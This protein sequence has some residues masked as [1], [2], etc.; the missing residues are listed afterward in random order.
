MLG[1]W[2]GYIGFSEHKYALVVAFILWRTHLSEFEDNPWIWVRTDMFWCPLHRWS[3]HKYVPLLWGYFPRGAEELD[4]MNIWAIQ[5]VMGRAGA[6]HRT[7]ACVVLLW[8]HLFFCRHFVSPVTSRNLHISHEMGPAE[9]NCI[10]TKSHLSRIMGP[11]FMYAISVMDSLPSPA[12]V[13]VRLCY[14]ITYTTQPYTAFINTLIPAS[15]GRE[16]RVKSCSAEGQ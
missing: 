16:S 4:F 14:I 9:R 8:A 15:N 3:L 2:C 6:I 12:S 7:H 13:N 5:V 11:M 10:M 1:T